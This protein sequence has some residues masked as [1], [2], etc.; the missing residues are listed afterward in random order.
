MN[1][2]SK[3]EYALLCAAKAFIA[4]YAG[5]SQVVQGEVATNKKSGPTSTS[6]EIPVCRIHGKEML[7]SKFKEG[8]YYCGARLENEK[9]CKEKA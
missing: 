5:A 1:D 7:P 3:L 2:V 6:N 4:V 9:Y 8:Q